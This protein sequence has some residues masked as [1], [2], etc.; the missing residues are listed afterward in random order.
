MLHLLCRL[1]RRL[2]RQQSPTRR[3]AHKNNGERSAGGG[4]AGR[5]C[6]PA[7]S[8]TGPSYLASVKAAMATDERGARRNERAVMGVGAS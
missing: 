3:L 6:L 2:C 5:S 8:Q 1:R 7:E 4:S